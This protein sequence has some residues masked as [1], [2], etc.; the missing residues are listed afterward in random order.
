MV[1]VMITWSVIYF[2]LYQQM[3][4]IMISSFDFILWRIVLNNWLIW[5]YCG[6]TV[7]WDNTVDVHDIN[8]NIEMYLP[9]YLCGRNKKWSVH[10]NNTC[11]WV[12]SF[13][14]RLFFPNFP[15]CPEESSADQESED[16]LSSSRTSLERQAPH[17]GNTTVHVCWHRNT[18]VSMVDF[19][20]ALEVHQRSSCLM[21]L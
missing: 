10:T 7:L 17:R 16:D 18:S 3:I 8:Q 12:S 15:E 11:V 5:W 14:K 19:S 2:Y 6:D 1:I 13:V 20:V 21:C 9:W 4:I